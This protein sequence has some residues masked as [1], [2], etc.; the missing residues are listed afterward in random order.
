MMILPSPNRV[1][2]MLPEARLIIILHDPIRRA[3]SWYQVGVVFIRWVWFLV[4][5]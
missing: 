4:E 2:Q 1:R 3:Y 5:L